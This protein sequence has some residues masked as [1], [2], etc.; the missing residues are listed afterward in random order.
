MGEEAFIKSIRR[1]RIV[2]IFNVLFYFTLFSA[3]SSGEEAT[4][5]LP[6][7]EHAVEETDPD[8]EIPAAIGI[9]SELFH[10]IIRKAANRYEVD[11]DLVKAIVMAESGYDPQ[12]VS[13]QGATGLM[14]LMPRTAE[15]LGVEDAFNPEHNV[16]A[17]VRYFKQLLEE[18]NYDIKLALAAYNAGS[19]AVK[20]HQGIP[21]IKATRHY[22]KKVFAYYRYYKNEAIDKTDSA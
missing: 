7:C 2:L 17:G 3:S 8:I 5:P 10:P 19:S 14:Q 15:A 1:G 6:E 9:K 20:R 12:A 13:S 11:P 18:F 16:N 4:G 22:V 21:P